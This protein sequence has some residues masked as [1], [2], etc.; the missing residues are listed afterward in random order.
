MISDLTIFEDY[1][2]RRL[3]GESLIKRLY[4]ID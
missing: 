3:Y 1:K 2:I 4:E